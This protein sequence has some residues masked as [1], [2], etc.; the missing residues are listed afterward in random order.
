MSTHALVWD[1]AGAFDDSHN[2]VECVA[3]APAHWLGL[4]D[5]VFSERKTTPALSPVYG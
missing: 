1:S 4:R 3:F 5:V 2:A